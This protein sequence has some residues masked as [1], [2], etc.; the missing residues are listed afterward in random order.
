MISPDFRYHVASLASVFLAL[1]VG[2]AIGTS[3]VGAPIVTRMETR[4]RRQET[5]IEE[6]Q[7][8]T[9]EQAGSEDALKALLPRLTAGLLSGQTVV[10]VQLG[11]DADAADAASAA[12]ERAGGVARRAA[13][14]PDFWRSLPAERIPAQAAALTKSLRGRPDAALDDGAVT[15]LKPEG[16]LQTRF[17]LAGS[18]IEMRQSR[19][20][21]LAAALAAG[22]TVVGTET[23]IAE[24]SAAKA[25]SAAGASFVDC[26]DRAAGQLALIHALR[27]EKGAFGLKQGADRIVPD[28]ALATP[29]PT[30]FPPA[31]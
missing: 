2:V 7:K 23:L 28:A 17:V 18:P 9:R 12:I 6:L 8:Q 30:L 5:R 22:A 13:L 29:A 21:P 31:P 25:F 20:V 15:A 3:V 11:E 10:V 27:G 4:V 24:P 1:G 16:G 19:D 14:P 26:V